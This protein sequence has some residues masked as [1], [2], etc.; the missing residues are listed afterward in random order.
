M[1]YA[2]KWPDNATDPNDEGVGD[3]EYIVADL[4]HNGVQGRGDWLR[5]SHPIVVNNTST[6]YLT[7]EELLSTYVALMMPRV[8]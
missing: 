7:V 3:P 1:H 5:P 2:L 6:L 4:V 8:L